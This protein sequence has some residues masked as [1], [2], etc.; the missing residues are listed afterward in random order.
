M[1]AYH[2]GVKP[3]VWTSSDGRSWRRITIN[4]PGPGTASRW[5]FPTLTLTPIG[6]LGAGHDGSIWFGQPVP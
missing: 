6:L 4:G 2:I 1:L 5:P 3:A